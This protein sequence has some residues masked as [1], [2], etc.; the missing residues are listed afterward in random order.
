MKEINAQATRYCETVFWGL[1][2]RLA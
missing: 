1:K 2:S